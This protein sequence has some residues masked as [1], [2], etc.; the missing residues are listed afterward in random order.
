MLTENVLSYPLEPAVSEVLQA[1]ANKRY[2]SIKAPATSNSYFG[3]NVED[4]NWF[5]QKIGNLVV[6]TA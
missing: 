5:K 1:Y 2:L 6:N 3:K 4:S